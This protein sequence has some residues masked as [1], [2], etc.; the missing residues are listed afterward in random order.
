[1][2][3]SI[4]IET[5]IPSYI[6]ANPSRQE[7]ERGCQERTRQWWD[8]KRH[9]YDLCISQVVL[10]EVCSG[11]A[12]M[13]ARRLEVLAGLPELDLNEDVEN[14]TA[15]IM[16]TGALPP[17]AGRD[18]A[19]IAVTCVYRI[20]ILLTWNCKHIANPHIQRQIKKVVERHGYEMPIL[21]TPDQL[22]ATESNELES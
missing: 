22:L 12:E 15:D 19:H 16:A 2:R 21:C 17:A 3:T 13:A 10:G 9:D 20:D 1:M 7:Y 4:Y 14:L 11:D 6:V 8:S 18:A 5:T